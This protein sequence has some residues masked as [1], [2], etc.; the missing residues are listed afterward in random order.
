M[1]IFQVE[2]WLES[3][4]NRRVE[5]TLLFT[6]TKCE[7]DHYVC[8]SRNEDELIRLEN[9]IADKKNSLM[10]LN[11]LGSSHSSVEEM[12]NSLM[13]RK[14]EADGISERCIELAKTQQVRVIYNCL[15][16]RKIIF[17]RI[18]IYM[19]FVIF[20]YEYFIGFE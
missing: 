2:L 3:L 1:R 6:R 4:H 8:L 17:F 14:Y 13:Q 10:R 11:Q 9:I 19:N 18:L 12:L 7:L 15:L 16:I 20:R 5:V